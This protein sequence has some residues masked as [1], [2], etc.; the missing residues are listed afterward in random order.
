GMAPIKQHVDIFEVLDGVKAIV[1][2]SRR[3]AHIYLVDRSELDEALERL[4]SDD[5]F[6]L[7]LTRDNMVDYGLDNPRSGDLFVA[8]KEGY[9]LSLEEK[10][11]G[12]CG[13]VSDKELMVFLMANKPEYADI[14]EGADIL[15]VVRAIKRYLLEA[16]AIELVRHELKR[17]DPV[18]DWGHTIRV[19]RMATKIALRCKA[20]VEVVRLAAIFHDAKRYLGAEG[21]EEA[22]ARLAEELLA[23]EGAPRELVERVKKVILSH[24]AQR[25]ELAT[26]E[27][28]VLWEADKLEVL[29]LVGLARAILE[30]KDIERGLER[31]LKRLGKYG[32]KI[33]L[34]WA[35]EMAEKR[36]AVALRAARVLKDELESKA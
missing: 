16:R 14:I 30:E 32:S 2:H 13:G 5:R 1:C 26:I 36:V 27:E 11:R 8:V 12:S 35:K 33:S 24:H 3:S 9:I 23:T 29:G 22:G 10:L 7:V 17:A 31:L 21:H 6:E 25:D 18:H 20:D 4:I 15:T 34:P 19:L 28:Q